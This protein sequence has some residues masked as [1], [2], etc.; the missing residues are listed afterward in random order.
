[1]AY[2]KQTAEHSSRGTT[3]SNK[4]RRIRPEYLQ[5]S[6]LREGLRIWENA[7]GTAAQVQEAA[8]QL[9]KACGG[10]NLYHVD[11]R[12]EDPLGFG[13]KILDEAFSLQA[14][15]AVLGEYPDGAYIDFVA[16]HY[17][18]VRLER[19]PSV[20]RIQATIQDHFAIY[21]RLILPFGEE[22]EQ[23]ALALSRLVLLVEDMP[24]PAEPQLTYRE[25]QMI[26]LLAA[27]YTTKGIGTR[28]G[29]SPK[30][31]EKHI[32]TLKQKMG[33]RTVTQAV[34]RALLLLGN[35]FN[36]LPAE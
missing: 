36:T 17:A 30:T 4:A 28:L 3:G 25:R 5:N 27:G 15:P 11:M 22:S 32:S 26:G 23:E 10:Q 21:E 35:D 6:K 24:P 1:M 29:I 13:F 12:A 2:R 7:G 20:Y 34:A 16:P 18:E 19:Q 31:V 8:A 33:A 14:Q 9:R